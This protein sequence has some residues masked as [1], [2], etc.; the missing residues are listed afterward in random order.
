MSRAQLKCVF[1]KHNIATSMKPH[2]TLGNF[3]VHPRDKI[4][5]AEKTGVVYK[6]TV[7]NCD[8]IYM[9]RQAES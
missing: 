5:T 3:L 9:G 6:I 7:N 2:M 1:G 4:D 8:K